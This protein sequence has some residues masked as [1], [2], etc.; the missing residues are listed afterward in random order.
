[1][2]PTCEREILA[3]VATAAWLRPC[4][5][6]H[7]ATHRHLARVW[8]GSAA[9]DICGRSLTTTDH[10]RVRAS[11]QP[12]HRIHC[13]RP[14]ATPRRPIPA[15]V[16]VLRARRYTFDGFASSRTQRASRVRVR[17]AEPT[18]HG[19]KC[20]S[21]ATEHTSDRC[22]PAVRSTCPTCISRRALRPRQGGRVRLHSPTR[23]T[24]GSGAS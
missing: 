7:C 8:P 2:R 22:D 3:A 12:S 14:A 13:P 9:A 19:R 15:D 17:D 20:R 21:R 6:G 1:M 16:R 4:S 23:T 10:P 24:D 18:S 5:S 11:P